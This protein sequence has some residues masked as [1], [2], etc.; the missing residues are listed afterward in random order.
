MFLSRAAF[1]R[2]ALVVPEPDLRAAA[3]FFATSA[4]CFENC[5]P[6]AESARFFWVERSYSDFETASRAFLGR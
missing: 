1:I 4:G 5:L 6:F 3:V 2:S